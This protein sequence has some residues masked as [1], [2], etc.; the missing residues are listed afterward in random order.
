MS[1]SQRKPKPLAGVSRGFVDAPQSNLDHGSTLR[2]LREVSASEFISRDDAKT[3]K[4][5]QVIQ[6]SSFA[7]L[8]DPPASFAFKLKSQKHAQA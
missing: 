8:F 1:C 6:I 3:A 5:T 2:L 4:N 7:F